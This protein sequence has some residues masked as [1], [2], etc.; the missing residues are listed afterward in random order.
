MC[1]FISIGIKKESE[2]TLLEILG[3]DYQLDKTENASFLVQLGDKMNAFV[4][5]KNMCACDLYSDPNEDNGGGIRSDLI[6]SIALLL[7]KIDE[8]IFSVHWYDDSI[9]NEEIEFLG[10]RRI[11]IEDL[12]KDS[13]AIKP[14]E[15]V[16]IVT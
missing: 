6:Q 2:D 3:R 11:N 1:F 4:L 5:S 16:E 9:E 8:L 12:L 13:S 14:D 15:I 7:G 10:K